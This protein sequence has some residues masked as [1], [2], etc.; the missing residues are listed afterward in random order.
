MSYLPE[1]RFRWVQVITSVTTEGFVVQLIGT[2][3]SEDKTE[4][5]DDLILRHRLQ[6]KK[7]GDPKLQLSAVCFMNSNGEMSHQNLPLNQ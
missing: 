7:D 5:L 2:T 1:K 3:N 6:L 4:G